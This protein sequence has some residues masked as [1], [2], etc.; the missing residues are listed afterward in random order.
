MTTWYN[1]INIF[2]WKFCI[3]LVSRSNERDG[4][5]QNSNVIFLFIS[6]LILRDIAANTVLSLKQKNSKNLFFIVFIYTM[7]K[8]YFLKF[9]RKITNYFLTHGREIQ[10]CP[11]FNI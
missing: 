8:P 3:K 10:M 6:H 1:S 11:T 7:L 4:V 9:H 5:F 2:K